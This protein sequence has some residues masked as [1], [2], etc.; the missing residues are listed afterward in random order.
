MANLKMVKLI[1]SE[2]IEGRVYLKVL[3]VLEKFSSLNIDQVHLQM[4]NTLMITDIS[5]DIKKSVNG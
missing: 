1:I 2:S 5:P 3:L 4:G